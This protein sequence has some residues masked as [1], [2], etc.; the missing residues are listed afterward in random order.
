VI[1]TMRFVKN[2]LIIADSTCEAY[3]VEEVIDEGAD[4]M[5]VNVRFW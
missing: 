1:P 2:A 4:G 5:F 3:L